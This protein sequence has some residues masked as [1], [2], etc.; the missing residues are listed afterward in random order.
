MKRSLIVFTL[1]LAITACTQSG[2]SGEKGETQSTTEP[3]GQMLISKSDCLTC[4]KFNEK[5][6]G[7]AYMD[8]AAKYANTEANKEMLVKKIINGG[9]GVWGEV[10]MAPHPTI[11]KED[12]KEMVNYIMSLKTK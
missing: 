3:V 2:K 12:A 10:P 6:V 9:S 11:S 1:S 7:P 8:V 5:L 4:H